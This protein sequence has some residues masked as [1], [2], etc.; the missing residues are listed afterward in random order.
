MRHALVHAQC[1]LENETPIY[2]NFVDR[3]GPDV[4]KQAAETLCDM[5]VG[6]KQKIWVHHAIM[7]CVK[8]VQA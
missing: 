6:M 5:A 2:G 3:I 8:M 7:K 1:Y 4:F